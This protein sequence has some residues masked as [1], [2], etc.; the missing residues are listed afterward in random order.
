MMRVLVRLFWWAVALA[1]IRWLW[2]RLRA[3]APGV[4]AARPHATPLSSEQV[5]TLLRNAGAV[6]TPAP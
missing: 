1:G 3:D 2:Q 4:D 6:R 5:E